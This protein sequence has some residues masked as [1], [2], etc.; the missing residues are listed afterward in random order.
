M[1]VLSFFSLLLVVPSLAVPTL[2]TG[3]NI[4]AAKLKLPSNQ[5]AL[6]EPTTAPQFIGL[7]VGVQNYTCNTTS[8][9]F[10][11]VGAVAELFDISYLYGTPEFDSVSLE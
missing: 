2:K 7:G 11:N 10:M 6:V 4:S 3:C 5:T 9:T 8:S 1:L